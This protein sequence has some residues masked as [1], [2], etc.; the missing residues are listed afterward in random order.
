MVEIFVLIVVGYD[1]GLLCC[2]DGLDVVSELRLIAIY[3]VEIGR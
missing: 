3:E 2:E 1:V